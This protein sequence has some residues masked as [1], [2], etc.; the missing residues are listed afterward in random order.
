M[1]S[2]AV[3]K[4]TGTKME[5]VDRGKPDQH[6]NFYWTIVGVLFG[7]RCNGTHSAKDIWT[8]ILKC[9]YGHWTWPIKYK[10]KY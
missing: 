2:N 10:L 5:A 6:K 8:K 7:Y 3:E 1:Q 9:L 4:V